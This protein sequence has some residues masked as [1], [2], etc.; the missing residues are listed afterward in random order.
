MSG[1]G[2]LQLL[3]ISCSLIGKPVIHTLAAPSTEP[4]VPETSGQTDFRPL[5]AVPGAGKGLQVRA[6]E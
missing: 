2:L 5:P 6:T 4:A 1:A 3:P